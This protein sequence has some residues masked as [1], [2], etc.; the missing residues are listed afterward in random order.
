MIALDHERI[1]IA[2]DRLD[3]R[4]AL[5]CVGE[6]TEALRPGM[7]AGVTLDGITVE[8]ALLLPEEALVD[9]ERRRVV[10]VVEDGVA[11][12]REPLLGAG[13]S[14]RLHI[15]AGLAAGEQ[16]V[17]AGHGRLLHGTAVLVQD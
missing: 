3:V 13:Y 2:Q 14:N 1:T 11:V 6:N 5:P 9:R 8:D 15:L 4:C 16:V 10:F 7:T 17:V 12:K